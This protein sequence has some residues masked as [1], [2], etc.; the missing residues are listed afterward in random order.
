MIYD[1]F[2]NNYDDKYIIILYE[3]IYEYEYDKI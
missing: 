3:Y 2:K 1:Y